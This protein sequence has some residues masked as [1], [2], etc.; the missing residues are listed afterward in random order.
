MGARRSEPQPPHIAPFPR[1][2]ASQAK[3]Q[4]LS[5]SCL[6]VGEHTA[7]VLKTF[8]VASCIVGEHTARV[9]KTLLVASRAVEES[10]IVRR[11]YGRKCRI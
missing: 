6:H 9:L 8:L 5:P 11:L 3:P 2:K 4:A 1:S 7:R 10:T